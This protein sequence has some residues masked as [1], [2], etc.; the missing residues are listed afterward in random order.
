M[1]EQAD[2][3][4]P[5]RMSDTGTAAQNVEQVSGVSIQISCHQVPSRVPLRESEAAEGVHPIKGI[6]SVG[7][8][9]AINVSNLTPPSIKR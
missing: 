3:S 7:Q 1:E 2:C 6:M 5:S 8:M 4:S 9:N